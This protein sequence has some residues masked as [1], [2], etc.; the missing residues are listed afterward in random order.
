MKNEL[1]TA[2]G[3]RYSRYIAEDQTMIDCRKNN[4]T[5][6]GAVC[7]GFILF[8]N[9]QLNTSFPKH[10]ITISVVRET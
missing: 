4:T 10:S 7:P 2:P 5:L 8:V 6:D 9:G 3:Q 1:Q